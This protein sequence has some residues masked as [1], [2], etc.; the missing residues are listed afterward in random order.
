MT[1][2]PKQV[3]QPELVCVSGDEC[4]SVMSVNG[5]A[6]FSQVALKAP[7]QGNV[8]LVFTFKGSER[9]RFRFMINYGQAYALK[10]L[11]EPKINP[12]D[13]LNPKVIPLNGPILAILDRVGNLVNRT[14]LVVSSSIGPENIKEL[15]DRYAPAE[16]KQSE[17]S[18]SINGLVEYTDLKITGKRG[19]PLHLSFTSETLQPSQPIVL[20]IQGCRAT[21]EAPNEEGSCDCGPG[22]SGT[23]PNCVFCPASFYKSNPGSDACV[24]CP[25]N[26]FTLGKTA[27]KDVND[28]VCESNYYRNESLDFNTASSVD[29]NAHAC[30]LCPRGQYNHADES[31]EILFINDLSTEC[32][33]ERQLVT[34]NLLQKPVDGAEDIVVR[35]GWWRR[36]MRSTLI[37]KCPIKPIEAARAEKR[38]RYEI[39]DQSQEKMVEVAQDCALVAQDRGFFPN[40]QDEPNLV[41][42]FYLDK[43]GLYVVDESNVNISDPFTMENLKRIPLACAQC[44]GGYGSGDLLCGDKY[45]GP[46]CSRCVRGYGK[47]GQ[48]CSPCLDSG[49]NFGMLLIIAC[50]VFIVLAFMVK[51]TISAGLQTE[52]KLIDQIKTGAYRGAQADET[53]AVN[54]KLKAT[55]LTKM[56]LNYLQLTSFAKGIEIEWPEEVEAMFRVQESISSPSFQ[57]AQIDCAFASDGFDPKLYYKKFIMYML[58][59]PLA[60][61]VPL[62]LWFLIYFIK[63]IAFRKP[64]FSDYIAKY[65]ITVLVI[66]F[67][68]HSSVTKQIFLMWSCRKLDKLDNGEYES[69]HVADLGVQCDTDIDKSYQVLAYIFLVLYAIGIPVAGIAV[70]SYYKKAITYKWVMPS[71]P[72]Y[73]RVLAR[74]KLVAVSRF[75]FLFKGFEERD[76]CPFWEVGPVMIRKVFF[77]FFSS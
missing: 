32:M 77:F 59:P 12:V 44:V 70:I 28:C 46:V 37:H 8:D 11:K 34:G 64:R 27:V 48:Y 30:I 23:S 36:S 4:L 49:R 51:N 24:P 54:F 73:D 3:T 33:P 71:H 35:P 69:Y 50:S 47:N 67:L 72:D 39:W 61:L 22:Y 17:R 52:D 65:I 57:I 14:G 6:Q 16:V 2:K 15:Y 31:R 75:G 38:T 9:T 60:L 10:L 66:L 40:P 45:W 68:T 1:F 20:N 58:L 62:G 25:R 43:S 53:G 7:V 29:W 13:D 21:T 74:D 26:M 76:I 19:H 55:L 18:E 41:N 63:K 56:A 42:T 5:V